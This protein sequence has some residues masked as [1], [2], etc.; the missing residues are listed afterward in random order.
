MSNRL[1]EHFKFF[2]QVDS[3][4]DIMENSIENTVFNCLTNFH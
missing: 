3:D 4:S 1:L 2:E